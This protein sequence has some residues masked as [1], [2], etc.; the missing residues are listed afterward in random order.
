MGHYSSS[1][2]FS[3]MVDG[4][5]DTIPLDQLAYFLDDL[6]VA[7]MELLLSKLASANLK[8]MPAKCELLKTKVEFV[9]LKISEADLP[10]N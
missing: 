5:L 3:R 9:G 7:S 1:S 10:N 6:M 4:L 8:L 2:Q